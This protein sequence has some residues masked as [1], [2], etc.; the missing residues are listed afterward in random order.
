M[1]SLKLRRWCENSIRRFRGNR[2]RSMPPQ[3]VRSASHAFHRQR[4]LAPRAH[5]CV[6]RSNVRRYE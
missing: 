2:S 5:S 3:R 1:T 6:V 4:A